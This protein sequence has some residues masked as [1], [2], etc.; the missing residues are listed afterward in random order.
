MAEA[1]ALIVSQAQSHLEQA[2]A[3]QVVRCA[4]IDTLRADTKHKEARLNQLLAE[5]HLE[6]DSLKRTQAV[7]QELV[8]AQPILQALDQLLQDSKALHHATQVDASRELIR[9]VHAIWRKAVLERLIVEGTDLSNFATTHGLKQP[10]TL[11]APEDTEEGTIATGVELPREEIDRDGDTA[12]WNSFEDA[13]ITVNLEAN[14]AETRT[15]G[16][17]K[18]EHDSPMVN[19]ITQ[20]MDEDEDEDIQV[21]IPRPPSWEASKRYW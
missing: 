16:L 11:L 5:A 4:T 10:E 14:G 3:D 2:M 17:V 19:H 9:T 12:S 20:V 21:I 1:S 7:T 13:T 8:S 6:Q 15:A 18:R